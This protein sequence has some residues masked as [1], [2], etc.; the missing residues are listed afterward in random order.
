VMPPS[1]CAAA[2]LE[3]DT[4]ERRVTM[5][6]PGI[7]SPICRS[8]I[9]TGTVVDVV[10]VLLVVVVVVEV[11][12]VVVL[13]VEVEVV[14]EV[15]LEV[16]ELKGVDVVEE[17]VVVLVDVVDELLLG[18]TV[19]LFVVVLDDVVDGVVDDVVLVDEGDTVV[20]VVVDSIVSITDIVESASTTST[21]GSCFRRCTSALSSDATNPFTFEANT[22]LTSLPSAVS[23]STF[24]ATL[25]LSLRIT[26]W[27][28]SPPVV[29]AGCIALGAACA[30]TG[31]TGTT[32]TATA[33]Q[34]RRAN[35]RRFFT[36]V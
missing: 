12:D 34:R 19:V 24:A 4:P 7:G 8:S 14:V 29:L 31:A 13:V 35:A 16:V 32:P 36:T 23:L 21:C 22:S 33:V 25:T 26:M 27:S 1:A 5:Y 11:V 30:A 15:L 9:D 3:D 6:S 18:G 2:K 10:E 28:R 20:L 17:E